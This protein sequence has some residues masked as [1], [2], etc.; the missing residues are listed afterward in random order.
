MTT[1]SS[2]RP[3]PPA[4]VGEIAGLATSS[5]ATRAS[6]AAQSP[7]VRQQRAV[8][9]SAPGCAEA[10]LHQLLKRL[11]ADRRRRV[12]EQCFSQSQRLALERWLLSRGADSPG[13]DAFACNVS[14]AAAAAARTAP[15]HTCGG[16]GAS[17][18]AFR[19]GRD[20]RRCKR[21]QGGMVGIHGHARKGRLLY[22]ASI[23]AGPLRLT[24]GYSVS[25]ERAQRNRDALLRIRAELGPSIDAI[26]YRGNAVAVGT[27]PGTNTGLDTTT[28][29]F[30]ERFRAAVAEEQATAIGEDLRIY[31]CATVPAG[32]WV[33]R[34]LTTPSFK[35]TTA[36]GLER[37]LRAWRRLNDARSA[38][39]W[40]RTNRYSARRFQCASS[41]MG[42]DVAWMRLRQVHLDVWAEAGHCPR[43]LEERLRELEVAHLERRNA[44]Q[45]HGACRVG[46]TPSAAAGFDISAKVSDG[47]VA[48]WCRVIEDRIYRLLARWPQCKGSRSSM[49]MGRSGA[50]RSTSAAA[51]NRRPRS[52]YDSGFA[53]R[54]CRL[55]D[56]GTRET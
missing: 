12:L 3:S 38:V 54:P 48:P 28:R 29:Q 46:S 32:H 42:I 53:K 49:E 33:G 35:A 30:E 51:A 40:G 45:R 34:P 52:E 4:L 17:S 24:T 2:C 43:R 8:A 56:E 39:Y 18:P 50:H 21:R 31:F 11:P 23:I 14:V 22:R 7:P 10:V 1:S 55:D 44:R 19:S 15:F 36:T 6:I 27:S 20:F 9:P 37:G 13:T 41:G 5:F 16:A 47:A 25:F 26:C